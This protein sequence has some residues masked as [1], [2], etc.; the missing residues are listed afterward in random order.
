MVTQSSIPAWR[1]PWTEEPSGLQSHRVAQRLTRPK[2]LNMRALVYKPHICGSFLSLSPL[3]HLLQSTNTIGVY[4]GSFP[5]E[6]GGR[7]LNHLCR[8]DKSGF[9][10]SCVYRYVCVRAYLYT[11]ET[12]DTWWIR[13]YSCI[14]SFGQILISRHLP[15]SSKLGEK[16]IYHC[17][18][19]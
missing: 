7:N 12:K 18:V 11:D 14:F 5:W 17:S 6:V 13:S 2:L 9:P 16:K 1:N 10:D 4:C 3:L 8:D 15:I 19:A